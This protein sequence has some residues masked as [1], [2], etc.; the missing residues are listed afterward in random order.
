MPN[1]VELREHLRDLQRDVAQINRR[2]LIIVRFLNGALAALLATGTY[3]A[4]ESWD[5]YEFWVRSSAITVLVV[6]Y[7]ILDRLLCRSELE[8]KPLSLLWRSLKMVQDDEQ[9]KAIT[10]ANDQSKRQ[11]V[12]R[13]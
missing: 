3:V 9:P 8:R 2:T 10:Q 1:D 7:L 6:S 11:A 12:Q 13:I 4:I 5:V